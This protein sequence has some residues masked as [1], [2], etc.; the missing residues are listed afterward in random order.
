MGP[1]HVRLRFQ[2]GSS[3]SWHP[4]PIAPMWLAQVP[5][6]EGNFHHKPVI[7]YQQS[8]PAQRLLPSVFSPL[9]FKNM[10]SD[11]INVCLQGIPDQCVF[12]SVDLPSH[13]TGQPC[14]A[15][16]LLNLQSERQTHVGHRAGA[17]KFGAF[18]SLTAVWC[19]WGPCNKLSLLQPPA[20]PSPRKTAS[21]DHICCCFI[22]RKP[23]G[24]QC[25][26][27]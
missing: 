26:P 22:L 3:G 27:L 21:L 1:C 25:C 24:S 7:H 6:L 20:Q 8:P 5:V 4:Y 15:L 14:W 16:R 17:D 11:P 13:I 10:G 12:P 18:A 23:H 19:T 9:L 2:A